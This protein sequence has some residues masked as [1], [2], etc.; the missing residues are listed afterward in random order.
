M[1]GS[2]TAAKSAPLDVRKLKTQGAGLVRVLA[3]VVPAAL[4]QGRPADRVLNALLRANHQWGSR[5]RQWL[6]ES[7]F[8]FFRWWGALRQLT[9]GATPEQPGDWALLAAA[10]WCL[11]RAEAPPAVRLLAEEWHLKLPP[12]P[13]ESETIDEKLRRVLGVFVPALYRRPDVPTAACLFPDWVRAELEPEADFDRLGE[14]CLRRPPMWLRIQGVA[15]ETVLAALRAAGLNP[16]RHPVLPDAVKLAQAR[17]NLYTLDAFRQGW[18]EVQDLASQYIGRVADPQVGERWWDCCAGAGGKSLQLAELMRRK[19][20]VVAGDLR[21]WKLD[22]LKL[23]ARRSGF[24]NI[25]TRP[26]D[27]AA[28]TGRRRGCFDGV[29][30]DAPC[31][32]SGVW[33]RNPDGRWNLK[34]EEV[35]ELSAIQFEVLGKAA[36][37]LRPGGKLVYATCSVFE[38]ENRG[39][40]RAFLAAHPEFALEPFTHPLTGVEC[41]GTASVLPWDGDCDGMFAARFRRQ[42]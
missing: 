30:V 39:V 12:P 17:V 8:A 4:N 26:W 24:P 40:V 25:T 27:G 21:A 5:D 41:D 37:A 11:E 31:S 6:S 14:Y 20:T 9:G 33:R 13:S 38:C 35:A 28:P 36:M 1:N 7:V 34:P 29:L 42:G 15:P 10:A 23:R 19:G 32:C 16:E 2:R 3:E 22:E 18:F